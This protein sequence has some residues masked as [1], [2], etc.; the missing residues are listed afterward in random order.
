MC[1]FNVLRF[2]L[3]YAATCLQESCVPKVTN[4]L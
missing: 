1:D 3:I 4:G 2:N